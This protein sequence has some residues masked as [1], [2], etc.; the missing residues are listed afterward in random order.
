MNEQQHASNTSAFL[1]LVDAAKI[2][3]GTRVLG[4]AINEALKNRNTD[5]REPSVVTDPVPDSTDS[6]DSTLREVSSQVDDLR[7]QVQE[8]S[9][10]LAV[11]P[12]E[13]TLEP[14]I[15]PAPHETGCFV[16]ANVEELN[17]A[18]AA[19]NEAAR[20]LG[21]MVLAGGIDKRV[22]R[23]EPE[24]ADDAISGVICAA[25]QLITLGAM[26]ARKAQALAR[27][28]TDLNELTVSSRAVRDQLPV[29]LDI[30]DQI[31]GIGDEGDEE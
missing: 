15:P 27:K 6:A 16:Q 22:A 5:Q 23:G 14:P 26:L 12:A 30:A 10:Q 21:L 1:A 8:L 11:L 31:E 9:E 4:A 2:F 29:L 20:H 19:Y 25:E 3:L 28:R 7:E 24:D 17:A 18:V 13:A